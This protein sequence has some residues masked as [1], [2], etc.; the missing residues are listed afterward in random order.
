MAVTEM[1][2]ASLAHSSLSSWRKA[3]AVMDRIYT[4]SGYL[5]AFCMFM[6][7]ALTMVQIVGRYVGFNP[8]GLT[9]YAGYLTG[10]TTFLGLAHTL[11][12]GAHVRVTLF[13]TLIGRFKP[14]AEFFGLAVSAVI[15]VWFSWYCWRGVYDSFQFGDLSDGLDATPLWI[16]QLSMA[17]GAALLAVA[18][19]DHLIRL[20]VTGDTGIAVSEEPV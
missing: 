10:A 7:F 9:N 2:T 12:R 13:L 6:I 18:V 1:N 8:P 19:C 20:L 15:G 11:N 17:V 3:W 4:A 5:A 14:V 16:P